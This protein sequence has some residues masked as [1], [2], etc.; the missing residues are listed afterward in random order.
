[1]DRRR[2]SLCGGVA[3]AGVVSL[4]G[5]LALDLVHGGAFVVGGGKCH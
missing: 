5:A 4:G 3:G 1:M 2:F